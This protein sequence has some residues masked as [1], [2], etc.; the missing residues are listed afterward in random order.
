MSS[1][2]K[3]NKFLISKKKTFFFLIGLFYYLKF[4]SCQLLITEYIGYLTKFQY[5]KAKN[6][7]VIVLII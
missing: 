2:T 7:T 4:L 6:I 3:V 1:E 5:E